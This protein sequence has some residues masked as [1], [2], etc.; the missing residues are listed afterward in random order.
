MD[1]KEHWEKVFS[2]KLENEVSWYQPNPITSLECIAQLNLSKDAKIIDVGGGDSYLIDRLLE[3]G[4]TNLFLLDISEH[5]IVKSKKR[6]GEKAEKVTFIVSDVLNF[7]PETP[8][9]VWH[10]RASFH[11][12]TDSKDIQQYAEIVSESVV[13]DGAAIIGTFSD[14]GP[15]KCSGLDITQ[16]TEESMT[17][18]F[19]EA[20]EKTICI[21]NVHRTPFETTQDFIFCIF[22]RK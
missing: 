20:F 1:K 11:F 5:A 3:E 2:T 22:K 9:D 16:Y 12:L 7:K 14:Q 18:V 17:E 6:L 4:F 13:R 8:F 15:K 21:T 10:D 19:S